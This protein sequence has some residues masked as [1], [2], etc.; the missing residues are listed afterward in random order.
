M[1]KH[2]LA[3]V[4][5]AALTAI[6]A[7]TG[8]SAQ[9]VPP[10]RG[11]AVN[12]TPA[13]FLQESFP[14]PTGN[15]N[16]AADGTVTVLPRPARPAN[17]NATPHRETAG[18]NPGCVGSP[19]CGNRYGQARNKL[20]RVQYE[21][22]MGYTYSFPIKLPDGIGGVPAVAL[23]SKNNLW[24]YQR[25]IAGQP[26]LMKFDPNMK[27]LLS[28]G[29]DVIGHAQKAH[30]MAV[31]AEDNA[32]V[33]DTTLATVKKISPDGKLL[34]TIGTNGKPGDWMEEKGQR[35]LWQP[36]MIAFGPNGDVWIGD[37]E[38]YR[39]VVYS[40]DGKYLKTIQTRNLVCALQFDRDGNPWMASGQ[41]GQFLKLD[42]DGNVL[43][44]IGG[45]MGIKQGQFIEASYWVFDKDNNLWA[46]DTSVGRVTKMT[47][48]KR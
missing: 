17:A 14:D 7:A 48:S 18:A 32:W 44:A 37:R 33:V 25:R 11:P 40:A 4:A 34:M 10:T 31:D 6:L 26:Q 39:I 12:G 30:G 23:D 28:V 24:V 2:I 43:G 5:A 36:V 19:I 9:T 46:G 16:V 29:D 42:H 38:Q 47:A 20:E 8:A 35:L 1:K 41:D 13:W 27:P 15:T 45:G 3:G 22:N 21:Q